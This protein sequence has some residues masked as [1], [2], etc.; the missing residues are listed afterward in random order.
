M[1]NDSHGLVN[2]DRDG[3][4]VNLG[5]SSLV[6]TNDAGWVRWV[7]CRFL[8]FC[9]VLWGF[10]RGVE[11]TQR[12]SESGQSTEAG[13]PPWSLESPCRYLVQLIR[14]HVEVMYDSLERTFCFHSGEHLQVFLD[15]IGNFQQHV[16][17]KHGNQHEQAFTTWIA[18]NILQLRQP[19]CDGNL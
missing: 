2:T 19:F 7:R 17:P 14:I 18:G 4:G 9:V 15:D 5:G 3:V 12:S 6:R 1:S 11:L 16:A 10:A 13:L 8:F